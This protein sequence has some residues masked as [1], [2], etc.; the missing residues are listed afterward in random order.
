MNIWVSTSRRYL[1]QNEMH[2]LRAI[3]ELDEISFEIYSEVHMTF[4]MIFFSGE[5]KK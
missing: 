5:N 4:C 1:K 3:V 2:K